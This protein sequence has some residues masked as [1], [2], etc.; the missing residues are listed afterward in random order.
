MEV[1]VV[2][3]RCARTHKIRITKRATDKQQAVKLR[4]QIRSEGR[5]ASIV[6]I[7]V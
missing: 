4:D 1:Y 3:Y 5:K 6:K 7:Y 2:R